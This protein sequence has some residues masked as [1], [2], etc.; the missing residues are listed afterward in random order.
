[1]AVALPTTDPIIRAAHERRLR[2]L[3]LRAA[4]LGSGTPPEIATEIEDIQAALGDVTSEPATEI[5]RYR[6][7]DQRVSGL[8]LLLDETRLD[9]KRLLWRLPMFML[10]LAMLMVLLVRL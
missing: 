5:D 6:L 8:A 2:R 4:E 9:V 3:Q 7:L 1:M 10:F